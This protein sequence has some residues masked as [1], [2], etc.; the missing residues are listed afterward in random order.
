MGEERLQRHLAAILAAD[1]A[2]YSRLMG[3]DEA[4]TI[5]RQKAH[6]AELI[7]PK[8]AEHNGRIVKTTGDGLLVEFGSAVDAVLC[9]VEVQRGMLEREADVA[10]D[11]KIAYRFGINVGEIVIDGDDILGDGVNIAARLEA[12]AEPGG[13]R[14]SDVVFKNV[15][16]KLD[17][18]FADL[19]PQAL[20]NIAEPVAA[21]RVLLDPADVGRLVAAKRTRGRDWRW[22]ALAAAAVAVLVGVASAVFWRPSAPTGSGKPSIAVLPLANPSGDPA[23]NHLGRGI[24]GDL[25]TDIA[26]ISGLLVA[27]WE[28]SSRIKSGDADLKAVGRQL[29]VAYVLTG[30]IRRI[31]GALRVNV[32]L[33]DTATGYNLWAERYSRDAK[34][35]FAL[36]DDITRKVVA[37]LRLK[38]TPAE[39]ARVGKRSKTDPGAYDLILRARAEA[40]KIKPGAN[41]LAI[42]LL[43]QAIQLDPRSAQAHAELA[44]QYYWKW[45]VEGAP[46]P[47]ILDRGAAF[48][49][50]AIAIDPSLAEAHWALGTIHR[51]SKRHDAAIR[52][53]E[54]AIKLEPNYSNS[55]AGLGFTYMLIGNP[56]EGLKY[57]QEARKR[58]AYEP[59]WYAFMAGQ[60]Y[61][62]L[63]RHDDAVRELKASIARNPRAFPA[64]RFLAVVY[65]EMGR[66]DEA[67]VAI[68]EAL[69]INPRL[70]IAQY[71]RQ[72]PFR[73]PA[74]LERQ[75]RALRKLGFPE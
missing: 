22:P 55:F 14:I 43:E 12:L 67:R 42:A 33:V 19:G 65:V 20:K 59:W 39:K 54:Q 11:R 9:A 18:G 2:G 32:R 25:F 21:Y 4:G 37:A 3:A 16:G 17:L 61:Y 51:W 13:I 60:C 10:A 24:A 44:V 70:S 57:V 73:N 71:K 72:L 46:D 66:M 64:H 53:F 69:R 40:E 52:S 36:Q 75:F 30:D 23:Q 68:K 6:R 50:K 62:Y 29:N 41:A 26:K 8:I 45:N 35:I 48:A 31:E 1:M 27:S 7:D 56:G 74:D 47:S 58:T 49:T 5:A 38:L 63:N 28:A 34:E 15:R